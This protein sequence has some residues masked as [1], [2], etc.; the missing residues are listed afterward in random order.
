[1]RDP[2]AV[3]IGGRRSLLYALLEGASVALGISRS[4]LDGV[5]FGQ[6]PL[7]QV[8]IYDN[9]P[10]GAGHSKRIGERFPEVLKAALARVSDCECGRETSCYE[11]LRNYS[12]Q[13]YHDTLRRDLAINLLNAL[14]GTTI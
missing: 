4:D 7:P 8:I 9:V 6:S 10:G 3:D 1:M 12:N 2:S 5:V 14:M 11:C 13:P